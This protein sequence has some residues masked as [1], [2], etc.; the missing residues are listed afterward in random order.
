LVPDVSFDKGSEV[1]RCES[2][3]QLNLFAAAIRR[4]G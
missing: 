2:T 4:E 1:Q 3:H